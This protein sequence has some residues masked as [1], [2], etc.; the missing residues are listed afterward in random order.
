MD[1]I[2]VKVSC[3]FLILFQILLVRIVVVGYKVLRSLVYL[4]TLRNFSVF[5]VL[6][7]IGLI[8]I[9]TC[10]NHRVLIAHTLLGKLSF[11][12]TTK[13][14]CTEENKNSQ[15]L[16]NLDIS[17]KINELTF[18][19]ELDRGRFGKV[20]FA[21]LK[22]SKCTLEVAVKISHNGLYRITPQRAACRYRVRLTM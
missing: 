9:F 6:V 15:N 11:I 21:K 22:K 17:I 8:M 1:I 16:E 10:F 18:I 14:I 19:K 20:M 13:P 7:I 5:M 2:F 3:S 12:K 4:L